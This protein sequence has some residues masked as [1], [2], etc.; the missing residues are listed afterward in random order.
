MSTLSVTIVQADLLWHDAVA[1]REQ[2]TTAIEGLQERSDLIVLPEMFT[3]GFSMDAP[4]LA[5]TMDGD[6]VSWMRDMAATNDASIC[7]SLIIAENG[8]YYNR[9]I[10]VAPGGDLQCYDKRHLFRLANEQNHYAPGTELLTFEWRGWRI[11]P[12]VCYDLRFPVWSRNQDAYDL[13]IYVANW[14]NRRHQAWAT[15]LRAR[16]IENLSYVVG[17]NRT[18]VDGN[19]FPYDGGSSIIDYLGADLAD[20]GNQQGI[21]TA[22]LDS[23]KLA[24]FRERFAFHKDADEFA[25]K[26]RGL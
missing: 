18:G 5:E 12:L 2:F 10:C 20:L 14:P 19:D 9:F 24:A 11:C 15:L 7:G 26:E 13:L 17:V 21:A 4:N 6:S 22:T 1:N 23:E 16:A 25:I 8:Q 3:T